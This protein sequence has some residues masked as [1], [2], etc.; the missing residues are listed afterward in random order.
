MARIRRILVAVKEPG[1]RASA[2]LA[3]AATLA[4]ATGASLELFHGISA[5]I[6]AESF[7]YTKRTLGDVERM[8]HGRHVA[9]LER[10]AGPLRRQ[11]LRVSAAA[12]WDF[13]PAE[14]IVR[15]AIRIKADLVVA[16]THAGWRTQPWLLHLTDWE[17]LRLCPAPVLLVK[18]RRAWRRP[19]VL[20]ALDPGHAFAKSTQLDSQI[21]RAAGA[22]AGPLRGSLHAM[23][24]F[25]AAPQIPV[26]AEAIGA[27][28]LA[29]VHRETRE[30]ARAS[31]ARELRHARIPAARRHLVERYAVDA[32]PGTAREIRAAIVVM[33]AV[34]RSGLR[35]AF[36]GNTA[37]RVLDRLPCDVLVVK[38]PRF[39]STAA[40]GRR[41]VRIVEFPPPAPY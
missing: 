3:K 5:P 24:A 8:I 22:V 15:R 40:R 10:L 21:L 41:G 28:Q 19:V 34:S 7:I 31:F 26:R 1:S 16:D 4:R 20:A 38:P 13:P 36:I 17:L 25:F 6:Q 32:I 29:Q 14:A 11:G 2:A 30:R 23:H 35:R 12:D 9:N 37:E 33:G 39:R 18:S 27:G